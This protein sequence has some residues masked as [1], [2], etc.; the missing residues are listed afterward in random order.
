[1]SGSLAHH[2][3]TDDLFR[4]DELW[5]QVTPDTEFHRWLSEGIDKD[6]AIILTHNP[7]RFADLK[8]VR[9]L[10]GTLIHDTSPNA[11]PIVHEMFLKDP[12]TGAIGAVTFET[13]DAAT[14]KKFDAYDGVEVSLIIQIK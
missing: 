6:V 10:T 9:I 2:R 3:L 7:D 8:G 5:M 13:T 1:V 4:I 14:A 11:S 12:A